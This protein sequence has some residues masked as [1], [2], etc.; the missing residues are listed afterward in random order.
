MIVY[1]FSA[2]LYI[3]A[4]LLELGYYYTKRENDPIV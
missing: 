1:E 2:S 4:V 3:Q